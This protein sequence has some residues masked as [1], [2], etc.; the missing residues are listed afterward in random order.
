MLQVAPRQVAV[1]LQHQ[2]HNAGCQRC[3]RRGTGVRC[4]A[5]VMQI[6]RDDLLLART[7]RTVRGRQ[8]RTALLRVPWHVSLFGRTRYGQRPDGVRVPIAVA[9]VVLAAA[10]ARCPHEDAALARPAL[11]HA[12][13]KRPGRHLAGPVN[14]FAIVIRTPRRRVNVDVLRIQRQRAC[15]HRIGDVSVQHANAAHARSV[16]NSDSAQ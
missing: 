12:L 9:V 4:R 2:R 11:G 15:L 6:G 8:R 5:R 1:G 7:A 14:G 10:V 16:R 3:R 13:D